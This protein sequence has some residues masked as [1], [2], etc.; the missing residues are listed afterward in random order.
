MK[1]GIVGGISEPIGHAA[2]VRAE[3]SPVIRH[4][5]RF[6][7]NNRNTVGEAIFLRDTRAYLA[8]EDDDPVPGSLFAAATAPPVQLAQMTTGTMTDAGRGWSGGATTDDAG[9][10]PTNARPTQAQPSHRGLQ[11]R[12]LLGLILAGLER[13]LS[14]SPD[15]RVAEGNAMRVIMSTPGQR[16]IT[17]QRLLG[18]RS[19]VTIRSVRV[20]MVAEEGLEPPTRGL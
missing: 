14:M 5:D 20:L 3:G 19:P 16:V 15:E 18:G 7:M 6:W 4:L 17:D 10:A 1:S 13:D 8:P 2:Q 9:R 11:R 12:G